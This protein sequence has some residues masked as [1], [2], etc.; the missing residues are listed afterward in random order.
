MKPVPFPLEPVFLPIDH[1]NLGQRNSSKCVA[2]ARRGQDALC[3][4]WCVRIVFIT[5]ANIQFSSSYRVW[6]GTKT[7]QLNKKSA[8]RVQFNKKK[9]LV[10]LE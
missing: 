10:L 5:E 2:C 7:F 8:Q 3:V 4:C 9:Y 6:S 1:S